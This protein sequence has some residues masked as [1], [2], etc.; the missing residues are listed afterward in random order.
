MEN[1]CNPMGS[2]T[3]IED[4]GKSQVTTIHRHCLKNNGKATFFLLA[5]SRRQRCSKIKFLLFATIALERSAGKT[6]K[7]LQL[8]DASA[9]AST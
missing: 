6:K 7:S 3:E 9:N 2:H 5:M 8:M 4:E 1:S